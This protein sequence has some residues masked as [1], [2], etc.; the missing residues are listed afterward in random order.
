MDYTHDEHGDPI[1]ATRHLDTEAR[2]LNARVF[3]SHSRCFHL[4]NSEDSSAPVKRKAAVREPI[5][6][7]QGSEEA[8]WVPKDYVVE[9]VKDFQKLLVKDMEIAHFGPDGSF[10]G[11]APLSSASL[12]TASS[13]AP[14]E[15]LKQEEEKP[16]EFQ[17]P[18]EP[19]G[20]SESLNPTVPG[21]TSDSEDQQSQSQT[22]DDENPSLWSLTVS[23][24]TRR[25]R[26]IPLPWHSGEKHSI[27]WQ[28]FSK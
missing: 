6:D 22:E 17:P 25:D 7:H 10:L 23:G 27:P 19:Q 4:R 12:D 8:T 15:A 5:T 18:P 20:P 2:R 9:Q 24:R 28:P 3:F 14:V 11:A 21:Q 13:S 26:F 16:F 1:C